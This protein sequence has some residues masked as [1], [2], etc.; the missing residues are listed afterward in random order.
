M[1]QG[2][3]GHAGNLFAQAV[4]MHQQGSLA[5]AERGYRLVLAAD[6]KHPGALQYLAMLEGQRDNFAE[7]V[8]LLRKC[9]KA[10]PRLVEAQTNLGFALAQTGQHAEALACYDKALAIDPKFITALNNRGISL[11]ELGRLDDALANYDRLLALKPDFADAH[12]NKGNLLNRLER[13]DDALACFDKALALTSS[14][15]N[16]LIGRATALRGLGRREEAI[17]CLDRALVMEPQNVTALLNE[18]H[19]LSDLR[20][21]EEA[22]GRFESAL[23]YDPSHPQLLSSLLIAAAALCDWART[24]P[25]IEELRA[26]VI[27]G[28]A[29][30]QPFSL[31]SA[32]DDPALHLACARNYVQDW[33]LRHPRKE[34]AR[35]GTARETALRRLRVAYLSA[36]FRR[37]ATAYL[38]AGLLRRH[39]RSRFEIV[40]VSVGEDDG[41]AE[42][43][44]IM[45][46]VDVFLDMRGHSD[47][48]IAELLVQQKIDILVDLNGHAQ[49][50]RMGIFAQRPAPLQAS[51]LGYPGTTG[52]N[53]LDYVIADPI[54]LPADL[55][56]F[57][58][59]QII[60]L[61]DYYAAYDPLLTGELPA[62]TRTAAGLPEQAF[63]FCCFNNNYKINA[64]VFDRWMRLLSA[65]EASVLWLFRDRPEVER[66]LRAEAERRGIDPARLLFAPRVS[67][68]EHL[69]RHRLADLFLD[70][71]PYNAHTTACDALWM[72][73]PIVTCTG[74]AFA[75]R[76]ATSALTS[77]GLSDLVTT[78]LEDYE[79]LALR[80]AT[81]PA[82]LADVRRRLEQARATAPVFDPDRLRRQIEAAYLQMW[83]IHRA[84]ASPRAFSVAKEKSDLA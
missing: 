8:R 73:L 52:V 20:R 41:S 15:V 9:V 53:Y 63:I 2:A 51:Y 1:S 11:R 34:V 44:Q 6:K 50:G 81:D 45:Q 43:A 3:V 24:Q 59:E 67:L 54:I 48:F 4:M 17:A 13:F 35:H 23:K 28:A 14:D 61:P 39:D 79:A 29:I 37:H 72:G 38:I 71:L 84:G 55:Q 30:G 49:G 25:L 80:L 62:V 68:P 12:Y 60:A 76:V 69:A 65:V 74:K 7:A 33:L 66:N 36:D 82:R 78:N 27:S 57:Y 19:I 32:C 64:A 21:Y 31:L 22:I 58:T 26:R 16:T 40:A 10:H 75:G 5:E 56:P 47:R 77:C 70:T 18:G 83:D 42:R 46:A